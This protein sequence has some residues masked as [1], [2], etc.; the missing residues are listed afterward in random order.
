[1]GFRNQ[2]Q[3]VRLAQKGFYPPS[4]L[5]GP[6][7]SNHESRKSKDVCQLIENLPGI[8]KTRY[9]GICIKAGLVKS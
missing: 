2:T 5:N 4:H 6:I 7:I 1:M 9:S 3:V 8:H